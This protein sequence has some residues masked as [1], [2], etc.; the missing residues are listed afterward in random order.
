MRPID[1]LRTGSPRKTPA[2]T[3]QPAATG[4]RTDPGACSTTTGTCSSSIRNAE[5]PP[6]SPA[7]AIANP[8]RC[9][10]PITPRSRSRAAGTGT[11]VP[12][13]GQSKF[14]PRTSVSA[15]SPKIQRRNARRTSKSETVCRISSVN[16]SRSSCSMTSAKR[17][18]K[19]IVMRGIR[20]RTRPRRPAPSTWAKIDAR[21]GPGCPLRAHTCSSRPHPPSVPATSAT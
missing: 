17:C 16:S 9:S 10:W 19:T 20:P 1:P 13:R 8:V 11:S 12:S 15:M 14:R 7:R 5:I 21:K 2:R 3:S 6:S 4:A 18:E